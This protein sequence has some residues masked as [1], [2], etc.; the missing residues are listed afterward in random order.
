MSTEGMASQAAD[1]PDRAVGSS[2]PAPALSDRDRRIL[3]FERDYARHAGAKD[4]AIRSEFGLSAARYY[5]I[6]NAVIDMPSAVVY[7]PMLVRRLQRMRETRM[8]A[9]ILRRVPGMNPTDR[10]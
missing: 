2:A 9:R 3:D 1:S 4:E 10:R 8:N 5:Q 7:D 6:L